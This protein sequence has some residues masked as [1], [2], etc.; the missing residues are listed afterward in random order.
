[1]TKLTVINQLSAPAV[2]A[3]TPPNS[4]VSGTHAAGFF[5]ELLAQ[6]VES[7]PPVTAEPAQANPA[8][9]KAVPGTRTIASNNT[10]TDLNP[11]APDT[12]ADLPGNMLALLQPAQEA[13]R[14][15]TKDIPKGKTTD[16]NTVAEAKK[17]STQSTPADLY[18]NASLL[19]PQE[20][21][22]PD[23]AT[24]SGD[25]RLTKGVVAKPGA[26]ELTTP[27]NDTQAAKDAPVADM[28]KS[29]AAPSSDKALAPE[30][31]S[32]NAGKLA[33]TP[34]GTG[35]EKTAAQPAQNFATLHTPNLPN[36]APSSTV[37][38]ATLP[39]SVSTPLASDGWADEFTQ[40]ISWMSTNQ[41]NQVAELHLNPPDLGPLNV[42]LKVTDNQATATFTSPHSA[43]REAVEN[44]L[45]KLR[46]TLADNG[47]TLGNT[48]VSDQP[49][50]DGN[51]GAF[52]GQQSNERGG[53]WVTHHVDGAENA[54]RPTGPP[55]T[56]RRH[57][58][59]V[60]TF[61]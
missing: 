6:Q 10:P 58:G 26:T 59:M 25:A 1:M 61:A 2:S 24:L 7:N 21:R 33:E 54:A 8:P 56:G 39:Q 27:L 12:P 20:I 11:A 34:Q 9:G 28:V 42:V 60:D 18:G 15:G 31:L 45:P 50:R 4:G 55:N 3:K 43:V 14:P 41:N 46:E 57:N 5:G 52:F 23:T 48:T 17:T 13:N 35:L 19:P 51:T 49:Q 32:A 36:G 53:R 37:H 44:A 16:S 38:P 29:Q 40:K 47:I 30:H 22:T